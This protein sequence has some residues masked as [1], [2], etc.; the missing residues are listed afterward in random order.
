MEVKSMRRK[1]IA[2]TLVVT[3]L[4]FVIGCATT[5]ELA[6]SVKSKVTSMTSTVDPALVSQVPADKRE[7]FAKAEYE[8]KV[9]SEKLKLAELKS[10]YG[11][12]QKKYSDY[13]EDLAANVRKEAEL[14]YDIVKMEAII[15][16]G[17]GKSKDDNVKTK[18]DLQSKKLKVQADRINIQASL[19]NTKGKMENLSAQIAKQDESIKKMKSGDKK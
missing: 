13:E 19:E 7:G 18:A 5:E 2:M 10:E 4:S 11:A 17:L 6:T 9:A 14:D 15:K 8:L 3:A 12:A 16:S 1:Y